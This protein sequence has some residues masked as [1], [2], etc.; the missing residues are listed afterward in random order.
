MKFNIICATHNAEILKK[1]L[2]SSLFYKRYPVT[3]LTGFTNISAAYNSENKRCGADEYNVY[4]HHDVF[5]PRDF[6]ATL[7]SSISQINSI[8]NNW[9]VLGVAGVTYENSKREC[10]GNLKDRGREWGSTKGLPHKVQTLDELLLITKG[11]LIFDELFDLHFYGADICMQAIKQGRKNYAIAAYV[12]HNSNLT[13]G[14][15]NQ[16]FRDCEVKFKN[17]WKDFLPIATTCTILQS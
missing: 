1:N 13:V 3:V 10:Y 6:E 7:I 2:G 15:R 8:D 4:A 9:G 11:D 16:S 12:H 17:K 14:F 5:M